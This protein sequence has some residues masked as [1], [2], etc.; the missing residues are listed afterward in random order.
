MK[1]VPRRALVLTPFLSPLTAQWINYPTAGIP[2]TPDGK[3]DLNAACPRT[4]DGKPDFSGLWLV[5]TTREGNPNFPGCEPVPDEFVNIGGALKEGLPFQPWA[6][7]LVK[8]RRG[9]LRVNDPIS[10]C[11]PAGLVRLY[12]WPGPH[13]LV[14]TAGLL[15]MLNEFNTSYRQI[16]TDARPLPADP[17]PSW[18]GYSSGKWE[19]DTLI[20]QTTGFR[21]GLWLDATGNPLTDAAK[22]TERFRRPNFGR[23]ETEITVNDPKA[24]TKPWTITL[25]QLIKLDT[26][27]L[28]FTCAEGEKDA[29]HLRK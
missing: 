23:L 26:D 21:D 27:L 19:G 20:V 22:I 24:Y 17:N 6:A 28:D 14:Q 3:P 4:S 13:K 2:R 29:S 12:T 5:Q 1:H 8:V 16:F 10:H 15:I 25:N 7:D 11:L 9:E 18:N